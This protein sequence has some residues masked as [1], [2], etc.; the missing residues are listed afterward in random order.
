MR[1]GGAGERRALVEMERARRSGG[2]PGF[3][4]RYEI[5]DE[6]NVFTPK[7]EVIVPASPCIYD[8]VDFTPRSVTARLARR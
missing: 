7:G 4:L 5:G 1:F 3:T 2:V 6:V 8:S